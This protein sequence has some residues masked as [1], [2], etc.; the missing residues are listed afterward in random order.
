MDKRRVIRWLFGGILLVFIAQ[1]PIKKQFGLF[2][3]GIIGP[4]F[5]KKGGE[6][7]VLNLRSCEMRIY[8]GE[9]TPCKIAPYTT[10]FYDVQPYGR[11]LIPRNNFFYTEN[12]QAPPTPAVKNFVK[13]RIQLLH[14]N[15]QPTSVEFHWRTL[16]LDLKSHLEKQDKDFDYDTLPLG[17]YRLSLHQDG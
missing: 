3:P 8:C 13:E 10:L 5:S 1:F 12:R 4:G 15:L 14:P 6:K 2:Y 16:E 11:W 17:N 7:G 9:E